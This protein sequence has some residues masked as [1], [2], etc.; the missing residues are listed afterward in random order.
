MSA[1]SDFF[2]QP[3]AGEEEGPLFWRRGPDEV[4]NH[5]SRPFMVENS[6]NAARSNKKR[7]A[8]PH[9]QRLGMVHLNSVAI[10]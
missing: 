8:V 7:N 9:D 3:Y 1:H 6:R 10:H 4:A 2:Q 5:L